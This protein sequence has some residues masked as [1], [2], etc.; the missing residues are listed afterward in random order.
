MC[1]RNRDVMV[2]NNCNKLLPK[3]R[4]LGEK[5]NPDVNRAKSVYHPPG[6]IVQDVEL[7]VIHPTSQFLIIHMLPDFSGLSQVRSL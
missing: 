7:N 2:M 1:G 6:H 4:C 3:R 5:F